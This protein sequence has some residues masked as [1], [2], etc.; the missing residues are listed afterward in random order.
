MDVRLTVDG[1]DVPLNEFVVK[2]LGGTVRG[3]VE[4]LRGIEK[5][6]EKIVVEVRQ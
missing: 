4:S 6:W 3:A 5:D 1:K 2:M